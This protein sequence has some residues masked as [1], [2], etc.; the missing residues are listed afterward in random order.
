YLALRLFPLFAASPLWAPLLAG[1]GMATFVIAGWSALRS[2]DLKEVLA[3]ST[4]AYLGLLIASLGYAA[5]GELEGELL[6]ITNHA[7]YKSSLFLL[8]GWIE[9]RTGTRDLRTL[10]PE[11][12]LLRFPFAA[13]LVAVGIFAMAGM[14]LLLGFVSKELFFET[15]SQAA[16]SSLSPGMVLAVVGSAL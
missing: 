10:E 12:W 1:V 2:H 15:V 4:S 14:P 5:G 11:R 3:Y 8:V 7:V 13:A 16:T 6:N 9:K